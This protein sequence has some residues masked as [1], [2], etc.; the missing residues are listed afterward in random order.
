MDALTRAGQ[1]FDSDVWLSF[2]RAAGNIVQGGEESWDKLLKRAES[3]DDKDI[4]KMLKRGE[5]KMLLA[6]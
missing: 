1:E 2:D 4:E 3:I 5:R 6:V